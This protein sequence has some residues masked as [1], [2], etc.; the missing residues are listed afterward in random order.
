MKGKS[1]RP[2][3]CRRRSI[4]YRPGCLLAPAAILMLTEKHWRVGVGKITNTHISTPRQVRVGHPPPPPRRA[5]SVFP[6][7][8]CL[9]LSV[10]LTLQYYF[11]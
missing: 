5:A 7:H 6:G 8:A 3:R 11:L 1:S 4:F 9:R 10:T 2:K